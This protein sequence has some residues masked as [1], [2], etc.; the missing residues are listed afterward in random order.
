MIYC[1]YDFL[2]EV[3]AGSLNEEDGVGFYGNKVG[4][5]FIESPFPVRFQ[6]LQEAYKEGRFTHIKWYSK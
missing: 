4:K 6:F 1:F 3:T 2:K 5:T